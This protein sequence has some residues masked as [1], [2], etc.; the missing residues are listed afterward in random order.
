[1]SERGT[2]W[3]PA[4]VEL[5][6]SEGDWER[7]VELLYGFFRADFIDSVP[8][9]PG[10]RWAMKRHPEHRGKEAT[11]WH[12]ISEGPDEAERLPDLRRC[13]RI[14]WPRAI[15]DRCRTGPVLAWAQQRGSDQRIVLALPDFSYVVVLADRGEYVLLWTAFPVER[16]HR[17]RKLEREYRDWSRAGGEKR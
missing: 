5:R 6:G 8:G 15:I 3:L 1:V 2:E 17:R 9:Y 7:Y 16:E 12:I 10:K 14:R 13:E 11:F 4:L